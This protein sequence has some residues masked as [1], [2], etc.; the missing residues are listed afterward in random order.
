[1][2]L[3]V[4]LLSLFLHKIICSKPLCFVNKNCSINNYCKKNGDNNFNCVSCPKNNYCPGDGYI[5][6]SS[7][8]LIPLNLHKT[9]KYIV[10][11]IKPDIRKLKKLKKLKRIGKIIKIGLKVA[12]IAKT[13]GTAALKKA[14]A[15]KAKQMAIRKGIQCLKNGLS[16]FCNGKK[17]IKPVHVIKR[18]KSSILPK[19]ICENIFDNI[20]NKINN[21]TNNVIVKPINN[22][23][24]W[25][26]QKINGNTNCNS[27]KNTKPITISNIKAK[28]KSSPIKTKTRP[29]VKTRTRPTVKTRTRPTIQTKTRPTIQTKT[30]PTIQTN[31]KKRS[32]IKT[33]TKPII[34]TNH[35]SPMRTRPKPPLPSDDGITTIMPTGSSTQSSKIDDTINTVQPSHRPPYKRRIRTQIPTANIDDTINT[36]QSS[37]TPSKMRYRS[38]IPTT[39]PSQIWRIKTKTPK[40]TLISDDTIKINEPISIQTK[41]P[42]QVSKSRPRTTIPTMIP[43]TRSTTKPS[44]RPSTIPSIRPSTRP[45][46]KPSIKPI[47]RPSMKPI[48]RPSMKPSTRPSTI[49]SMKPSIKLSTTIPTAIPSIKPTINKFSWNIFSNVPTQQSNIPPTFFPTVSMFTMITSQPVLPT[50]SPTYLR[51]REPTQNPS[52]TNPTSTRPTSNPT[53]IVGGQLPTIQIS[54]PTPTT[55]IPTSTPTIQIPT[56]I[57]TPT[58]IVSKTSDSITTTS[59]ISLNITI[60]SIISTIIVLIII[61]TCLCFMKKKPMKQMNAYKKWITH[62]D[63]KLNKPE[64]IKTNKNTENYDDMY[65]F[66][67]KQHTPHIIS[68]PYISSSQSIRNSRTTIRGPQEHQNS[69]L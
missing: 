3:K 10:S 57:P 51:T 64:T 14:A 15:A 1:M 54:T 33:R 55:Q 7:N 35:I 61:V 12:V 42:I 8:D 29:T 48:T 43:S 22:S 9:S 38:Q 39:R 32:P 41:T 24:D 6:K 69:Q 17:K 28:K 21:A 26:K 68:S 25:L 34:P 23:R 45:S 37:H 20:A 2:K 67:S 44:T 18:K 31:P 56:P 16:N 59:K 50:P 49:P 66:Y 13:G 4:V 19:K 5:Y 27:N 30:R 62:Y 36:F 58:T 53:I 52:T 40:P 63:S 47:T 60:I 65:H 11:D 46:I